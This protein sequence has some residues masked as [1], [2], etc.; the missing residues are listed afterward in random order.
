[1]TDKHI[2]NIGSIYQEFLINIC[3]L[4]KGVAKYIKQLLAELKE[5]MENNTIVIRDFNT[6]IS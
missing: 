2:K 3:A 4:N 5:N 1:M 6:A